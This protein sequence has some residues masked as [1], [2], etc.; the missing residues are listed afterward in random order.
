MTLTS[1]DLIG[2]PRRPGVQGVGRRIVGLDLGADRHGEVPGLD[3]SADPRLEWVLRTRVG[4][5][6]V[7]EDPAGSDTNRSVDGPVR[8]EAVEPRVWVL[9]V[10]DDVA[11]RR[12][13]EVRGEIGVVGVNARLV[14][15]GIVGVQDVAPQAIVVGIGGL[16]LWITLV[17]VGRGTGTRSRVWRPVRMAPGCRRWSG[18]RTTARGRPPLASALRRCRGDAAFGAWLAYELA[19]AVPPQLATGRAT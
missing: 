17:R 12:Q 7:V 2:L 15:E 9:A 11:V 5:D 10:E 3:V 4:V 18:R 16:S 13:R 19:T 14:R 8:R 1:L 6:L